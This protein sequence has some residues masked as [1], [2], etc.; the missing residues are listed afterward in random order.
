LQKEML[1]VEDAGLP[2]Q[3]AFCELEILG[4]TFI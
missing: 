3:L 1:M 2:Y 4:E